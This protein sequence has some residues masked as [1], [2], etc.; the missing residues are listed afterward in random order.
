MQNYG[1]NYDEMYVYY[2][3]QGLASIGNYM[4]F[5]EGGTMEITD[6]AA[7][8]F[9]NKN[10]VTVGCIFINNQNKSYPNGKTVYLPEAEKQAKTALA[11]EVYQRLQDGEDF[12][13]LYRTYSDKKTADTEGETYTFTRG[14][15]GNTEV[16][17][18]AFA[19]T[20]GTVKMVETDQ[21]IFILQRRG[22]NN[23]YFETEKDSITTTLEE[24]KKAELLAA[25]EK[26]FSVNE[27]YIEELSVADLVFVR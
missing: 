10:Y 4:L 26:H 27:T 12:A 1:I 22:L 17:E 18:A 6:E 14:G 20:P 19:L 7:R 21:G 8:S 9:Y 16:E 15:F 11:H 24:Q 5:G 23:K 13:E 25:E 3:H 2:L